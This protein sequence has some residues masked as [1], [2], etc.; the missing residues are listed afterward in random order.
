[1]ASVP[2]RASADPPRL[3]A[4]GSQSG[5]RGRPRPRIKSAGRQATLQSRGW[6][7][8]GAPE[9]NPRPPLLS[10]PRSR[11]LP[12]LPPARPAGKRPAGPGGLRGDARRARRRPASASRPFP[13]PRPW[14][15]PQPAGRPAGLQSPGSWRI[16]AGDGGARRSPGLAEGGDLFCS[17]AGCWRLR[18]PP[19]EVAR[20][21]GVRGAPSGWRPLWESALCLRRGRR[22]LAIVAVF[23]MAF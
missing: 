8:R 5:R 6:E 14:P 12:S 23:L 22:A 7:K 16:R 18:A 17:P 11:G 4:A 10:A 3:P 21:C 20:R 19:L 2:G 15:A 13:P 1:M 9:Q